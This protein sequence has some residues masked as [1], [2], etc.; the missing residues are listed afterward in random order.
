MSSKINTNKTIPD[1][2]SV[3]IAPGTNSKPVM[4]TFMQ[5]VKGKSYNTGKKIISDVSDF[6]G[7][8]PGAVKGIYN[9]RQQI[10]LFLIVSALAIIVLILLFSKETLS[11]TTSEETTA[12]ILFALSFTIFIVFVCIA[13]LPDFTE[14]KLLLWSMMNTIIVVIFTI[15]LTIVYTQLSNETLHDY[16]YIVTPLT[17]M[18]TMLVFYRGLRADYTLYLNNTNQEQLKTMIMFLCFVVIMVICYSIDPGNYLHK[19]Y[20]SNTILTIT[21]AIIT[22]VYL[23][24]ILIIP[25]VNKN[26]EFNLPGGG[27]WTNICHILYLLFI[28]VAIIGATTFKGGFLNNKPVSSAVILLLLLTTIIWFIN[29]F[30]NSANNQET[31]SSKA[32]VERLTSIFGYIF[33]GSI[34]I[35]FLAWII[36]SGVKHTNTAPTLIFLLT[37]CVIAFFIY[38][39]NYTN[40][41]IMNNQKIGLFTLI[42]NII[43]YVPCLFLDIFNKLLSEYKKLTPTIVM[44]LVAT[45]AAI[46]VYTTYPILLDTINLQGGKQLQ[47]TP[48]GTDTLHSLSTYKDMNDSED[49][50]YRYGL[51]FWLYLN[52]EP[53]NTG[54]SYAKYT[55][56]LNYG[57]KPNI[58][59]NA[60]T[61]TLV[62]SVEDEIVYETKDMRLQKWNNIVVNYLGGTL[63]VFLNGELV[64]SKIRIVPYMSLDDLVVGAEDGVSGKICNVVYFKEPLTASKMYYL[65]NMVKDSSPPIS[66]GGITEIIPRTPSKL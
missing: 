20:N 17:I 47:N 43:L 33:G 23:L 59:Y 13:V 29:T 8:I 15:I 3:G 38:K 5:D 60:Q 61:N 44:V 30:M 31:D 50:N 62:I 66:Y 14:W 11:G 26:Y 55:S 10:L 27:K 18:F 2:G 54:V 52:A 22:F 35:V 7:K 16:A 46:S 58:K 48:I 49:F 28:I 12:N 57:N 21:I 4:R 65:Y 24:S 37:M 1:A 6:T 45:I 42:I 56:L 64:K 36:T 63:D 9:V 41:P 34:A 25:N 39:M 32:V 51:S 40:L 53:P 19:L